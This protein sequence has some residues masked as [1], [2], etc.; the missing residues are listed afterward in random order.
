MDTESSESANP[1][2]KA[3]G[4]FA[5]TFSADGLR[6][7]VRSGGRRTLWAQ[8]ASHVI[9]LVVLATLMRQIGPEN[10]GLFAMVVPLMLL[11]RLGSSMGMNIATVQLPELKSEQVSAAFWMHVVLGLAMGIATLAA[12]PAVAW[13]NHEPDLVWITIALMGTPLAS[14]V[15]LQHFSL[16]ERNLRLGSAAV[17][18]LG[19]QFLG[20]VAAI[21]VA[22]QGGGVWAL[23]VQQY[24]E[25]FVMAGIAWYLEP[26]RPAKPGRGTPIGNLWRF[27]G[28]FTA[29]AVV[30]LFLTSVDKLLLGRVLSADLG[31]VDG[32]EALGLYSQAFSLMNKPIVILATPLSSI[33]LPALARSF[34]D[35]ASFTQ[36]VLAFQRLVAVV[37]FPAA[38]GLMA[39][40]HETMLTF[41][42]SKWADAGPLLA[43]LSP[44]VFAMTF[45]MT[46]SSVFASAGQWRAMFIGS[47]V[48]AIVLVQGLFVGLFVGRQNGDITLSVAWAYSLTTCLAT[49]GPY[50]VFCMRSIGVSPWAWALQLFRPASSALGMGVIVFVARHELLAAAPNLGA[51]ARLLILM[52]IGMVAYSAL[53]WRE[54]RWCLQQFRGL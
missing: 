8:A 29:S 28:Y 30:L 1:D 25:L 51:S 3:G 46:S 39:V 12:A 19:A 44:T 33:M 42:G 10:F 54:L 37:S 36:I 14:S 48:I 41:G 53:A 52:T 34:H 7:A 6:A 35:R 27:G 23:V 4:A 22:W 5:T 26:W 40:S 16:L 47:V 24:A 49:F 13:F 9:S 21:Y 18:R 38:V 17:A 50:M 31:P 32:P 15:G 45:I 2:A 20:G 43:A 11:L